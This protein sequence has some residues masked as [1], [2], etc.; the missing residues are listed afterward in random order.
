M[1]VMRHFGLVINKVVA[2]F[3]SLSHQV[4]PFSLLL[5]AGKGHFCFRDVLLV[6]LQVLHQRLLSPGGAFV[7][8]GI[9]VRESR[10]LTC[11]LP[12]QTTKMW[13]SLMFASLFHGKSLG[14]F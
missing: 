4:F 11:I 2:K 6:I 9:C 10:G 8:V 14:N 7:L 3:Y 5:N 13:P 1:K 12:K